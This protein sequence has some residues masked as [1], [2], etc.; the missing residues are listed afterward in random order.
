MSSTVIAVFTANRPE[1]LKRC[2]TAAVAGCSVAREAHWIVLDDSCPADR[3]L[4]R[5]IVQLWRRFGLQVTYVD[6]TV[7][8]EIADAL[9]GS[10]FRSSFT[11]LVA[12]PSSYRIPGARNLALLIGLSLDP[13]VLFFVDDDIVHRHEGACF[14]HWCTNGGP[15]GSFVAAP[16]KLG[17][18]DQGYL[19]RLRDV[20]QRDDWPRFISGRGI[21]ADPG[22]WYSSQNPLWK[23]TN[24]GTEQPSAIPKE[25]G[26][27]S[28]QLKEFLTT[29]LL[30]IRDRGG[31]W[32]PFPSGIN[33]D[34]NWSFL[35]SSFHGTPLLQVRNV[36]ARHLPPSIGHWGAETIVSDRVGT[37][38]TRA[39]RQTTRA[40]RQTKPPGEWSLK[41][42]ADRFQDVMGVDL[43]KEVL[44]LLEV[45]RSIRLRVRTCVDDENAIGV[46]SKIEST[47]ID[48][49]ERLRALDARLIFSEWLADMDCRCKMFLALR[50]NTMIQ[51]R[52]CRV[53][54]RA[55]V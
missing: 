32:L 2:V 29:Q 34:T 54:L 42:L 43:K 37:A 12:R 19:T 7:E 21:M 51:A 33:E 3:A 35:Q 27:V 52:I 1:S 53:L 49:K 13:E 11:H 10:T 47:L 44:L 15:E 24:D 26:G 55:S 9:P 30:A 5:E 17:I 39:L 16:R 4:N 40:L 25:S 48:A 38:I 45:E 22:L 6:T 28:T 18:A 14:F 46:L 31:E 8:E 41:T 50:R 23:R 20:L 36:F